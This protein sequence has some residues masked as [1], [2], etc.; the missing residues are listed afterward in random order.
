MAPWRREKRRRSECQS[1][2][3]Q[4]SMNGYVRLDS[5]NYTLDY[6]P[7][8]PKGYFYS[9]E[10]FATAHLSSKTKHVRFEDEAPAE[11]E[12]CTGWRE[13]A[14]ER[15]AAEKQAAKLLAK[16][17]SDSQLKA[18]KLRSIAKAAGKGLVD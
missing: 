7:P 2:L 11:K 8:P 1:S 14:A 9:D 17:S 18:R 13:A 5:T 3:L 16:V 6:R 15:D 12:K 10:L 4:T